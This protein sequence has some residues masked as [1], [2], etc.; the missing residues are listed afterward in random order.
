[1]NVNSNANINVNNILDLYV[2]KVAETNRDDMPVVE[3]VSFRTRGH[4]LGKVKGRD[5]GLHII[6]IGEDWDRNE[7]R[8]R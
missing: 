6:K 2:C 4:K 8:R 3:L 5:T 1:M 7:E